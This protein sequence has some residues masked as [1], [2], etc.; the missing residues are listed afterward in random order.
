L[1][2]IC[3]SNNDKF[4]AAVPIQ[5]E[6]N[7]QEIRNEVISG[8]TRRN[9][10]NH[11]LKTKSRSLKHFYDNKYFLLLLILINNNITITQYYILALV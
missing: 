11:E 3:I 2:N 10:T 4:D 5:A 6:L 9:L 8:T 7:L 1:H